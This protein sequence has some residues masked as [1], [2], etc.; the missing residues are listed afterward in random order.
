VARAAALRGSR[1]SNA[2]SR[3]EAPRQ[4]AVEKAEEPAADTSAENAPSDGRGSTF[5]HS[6]AEIALAAAAD[7]AKNCRPAGG[8][9][10]S[11]TVQ[12]VYEPS[13]KV[14]SALIL[15]PGFENS[16]AESCITMLFRR[17]RVAPFTGAKSVA[18]K[19]RFEIP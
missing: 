8:P 4:R 14:S 6:A 2:S 3:E 9:T 5:D 18:V 16:P 19:Q 15:T 7:Q 11:G 13:G 10:G 1:V 12:V 17:A